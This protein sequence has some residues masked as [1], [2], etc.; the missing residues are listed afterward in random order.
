MAFLIL[1][2]LALTSTNQKIRKLGAKRWKMIHRTIYVAA[3]FVL[4][5]MLL[6][7]KSDPLEVWLLF[8]PLMF[9]E[10]LRFISWLKK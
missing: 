8:L 5:H 4:L 3:G 9:A 2:I 1:L 10:I 7:E 6:K